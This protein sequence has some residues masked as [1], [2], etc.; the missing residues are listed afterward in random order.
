MIHCARNLWQRY[1]QAARSSGRSVLGMAWE[2]LILSRVKYL[3]YGLHARAVDGR[4]PVLPR[5]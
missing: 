4:G 1:C 3:D 2:A 5:V